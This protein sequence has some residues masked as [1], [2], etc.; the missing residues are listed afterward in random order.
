MDI[1]LWVS[2]YEILVRENLAGL[3]KYRDVRDAL[4]CVYVYDMGIPLDVTS[5]ITRR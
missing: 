2:V 4:V 5:I 1:L 3:L